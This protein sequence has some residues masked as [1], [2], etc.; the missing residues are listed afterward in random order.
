LSVLAGRLFAMTIDG[1]S[2]TA[3]I[4][5]TKAG[6]CW[7]HIFVTQGKTVVTAYPT[8]V[9]AHA[10]VIG[11]VVT[12]LADV[13]FFILHDGLPAAPRSSVSQYSV[14]PMSRA[15]KSLDKPQSV[16]FTEPFEQLFYDKG[17]G[18]VLVEI[19]YSR[20]CTAGFHERLVP[21]PEPECISDVLTEGKIER[22]QLFFL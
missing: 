6:I 10:E 1:N 13:L 14:S 8:A 12:R 18:V 11:Y 16:S 5:T 19:T 4:W 20:Q 15:E 9:L 21:A 22:Y 2:V 3:T 17:G 7:F